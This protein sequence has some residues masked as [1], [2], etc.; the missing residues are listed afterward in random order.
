MF[1]CLVCRRGRRALAWVR[2]RCR[3]GTPNDTDDDDDAGWGGLLDS[4]RVFVRSFDCCSAGYLRAVW[5]RGTW[6]VVMDCRV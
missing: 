5:M 1:V 2:L 6:V 3:Y 4:A